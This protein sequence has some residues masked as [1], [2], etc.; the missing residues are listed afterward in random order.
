MNKPFAIDLDLSLCIV[1]GRQAHST[2]S[3]RGL[4]NSIYETADSVAFEVVVAEIEETGAAALADE[5]SGLLVTRLASS[6][7]SSIAA[8]NHIMRLGRGR[9]TALLDADVIIQPG[10]LERLLDFMDENPEVG[11]AGPRIIDAY[12]ATEASVCDFPRLLKRTGVPLPGQVLPRPRTETGEV[13]WQRGGFHLLRRELILE[14]G[15]LDEA[16]GALAELDLYWRARRHG[17]HSFY[18]CEAVAVHANPGRYHPEL[19]T[20]GGWPLRA[21]EIAYFLK[22]RWLS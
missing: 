22:K 1:A 14:I 5:F 6:G 9:Y 17:W 3:L 18:V 11:L 15:L 16:C 19:P 7:V 20:G 13:D 10:C 21:K 4:L 8:A 2:K 12:G